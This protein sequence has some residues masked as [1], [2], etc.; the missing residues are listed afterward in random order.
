MLRRK[1]IYEQL[2]PET[3]RGQYGHK[4]TNVIRKNPEK[5]II[6]FSEDTA[7]KLG[8]TART[9]RKTIK[10]ARYLDPEVKE[11]VKENDV[12]KT[13]AIELAKL[14]PEKQKEITQEG[15]LDDIGSRKL[16]VKEAIRRIR[17]KEKIKEFQELK[18][19][20]VPLPKRETK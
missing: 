9:I 1:E 7:Q 8:K 2:H 14:E 10:I 16:K 6:S 20:D 19:K 12:P 18:K 3:K 15:L 13:E 5:E 17:E 11:K 4:G